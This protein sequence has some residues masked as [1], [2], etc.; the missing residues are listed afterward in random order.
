[1][2]KKKYNG[3]TLILAGGGIKAASYLGFLKA[4]EENGIK[5]D[6]IG[7]FSGGALMSI[8]YGLGK[9]YNYVKKVFENKTLLK[10]FDLTAL[11][12]R[13]I[14]SSAKLNRE[15][16]DTIGKTKFSDLSVKLVIFATNITKKRLEWFDKGYV[17]DYVRASM[18]LTPVI[19]GHKIKKDDYIDGG[20][21]TVF[22][23]TIMRQYAPNNLIIGS[24]PCTSY[25]MF[26]EFILRRAR[27]IE[28]IYEKMMELMINDDPPDLLV[29]TL[30]ED[31]G[32]G[33]S[34]ELVDYFYEEGY[35]TGKKHV[36]HIMDLLK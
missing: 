2:S 8:A 23:T 4:L 7:A 26:P 34:F 20:F 6:T 35:K 18:A 31:K 3:L 22:P 36:S 28:F 5:P 24:I 32:F 27:Y 16:E 12:E 30:S 14:I 25:K 19:S 10:F 9:D 29:E 1:M 11:R 33:F 15:L 17:K 21:A 13:S